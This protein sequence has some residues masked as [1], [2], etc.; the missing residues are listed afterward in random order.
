MKKTAQQKIKLLYL[1]ELLKKD[2]GEKT[3]KDHGNLR[4]FGTRR[5]LLRPQNPIP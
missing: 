4:G 3:H 1:W 5:D 2:S